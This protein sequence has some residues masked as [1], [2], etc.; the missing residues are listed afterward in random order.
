MIEYKEIYGYK[1]SKCGVVIGRRGKPLSSHD[2]GRGYLIVG[3]MV[4]GKNSSKAVHRLVAEAWLE[5]PDNLEEVNHIDCDKLNN[6]VSNLEW[7]TRGYNIEYTYKNNGRSATGTNNARCKVDENIVREVCKLLVDGKSSA[8]IRD[9]G[10]SYGMV[11]NIKRRENWTHISE[12]Y[13]W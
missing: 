7:C 5:N 8:E 6:H 11:R 2:N 1:V 10:Y 13:V 3:V 4:N 12:D 9:L